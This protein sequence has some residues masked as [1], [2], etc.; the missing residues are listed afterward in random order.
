MEVSLGDPQGPQSTD[1]K[2]DEKKIAM[3]LPPL[4]DTS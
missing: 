3:I 4:W 1:D 2:N